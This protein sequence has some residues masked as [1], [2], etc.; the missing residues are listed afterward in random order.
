M[1]VV[2]PGK[3]GSWY[4]NPDEIARPE[5]VFPQHAVGVRVILS[6]RYPR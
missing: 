5:C 6:F 1:E 2:V 3:L 4:Q